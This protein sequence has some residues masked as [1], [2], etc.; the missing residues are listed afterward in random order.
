MIWRL[1]WC[2]L[3]I[4]VG[5]SMLGGVAVEAQPAQFLDAMNSAKRLEQQGNMLGAGLQYFSLA[6]ANR[7]TWG[8]IPQDVRRALGRRGMACVVADV[9]RKT[10]ANSRIDD[11]TF[12][13]VQQCYEKMQHLEPDNSTWPY[14]VATTWAAQGRYME[15]QHNLK[16]A[17]R[18]R[19]SGTGA[20]RKMNEIITPFAQKDLE[21]LTAMDMAAMRAAFAASILTRGSTTK[22]D[23]H[24]G[25]AAGGNRAQAAGDSAAAQR[26]GSGE[27]SEGDRAKYGGY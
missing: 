24:Y 27:A 15:A 5:A 4:A 1:R 12:V 17:M 16:R 19:G 25:D 14:L 8:A 18:L 22:Y 7:S 20:A 6:E 13:Q 9:R 10:G 2:S 26:F 3:A 11:L 23:P 21:R